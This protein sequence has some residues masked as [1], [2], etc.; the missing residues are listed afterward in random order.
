[1]RV[2]RVAALSAILALAAASVGADVLILKTGSRTDVRSITVRG[3]A[4]IVVTL[5]GKTWSLL[6]DAVDLEATRAANEPR[7][8]LVPEPAIPMPRVVIEPE[9]PVRPVSPQADPP[10][11]EERREAPA[12]ERRR[13]R[14]QTVVLVPQPARAPSPS[15]VADVPDRRYR[16]AFF[17]NGAIA[18]SPLEFSEARSFEL[19]KED[20]VFTNSYRDP[21]SQGIELGGSFRIKGPVGIGVSVELFRNDRE[22]IYSA[23]LPHPFFFEQFRE[24]SG[25]E[26]GLSHQE[27][28]LHLDAVVTAQLGPYV[29]IDVFGGPSWFRT[30]TELLV[31]VRYEELY[32]YH[33]VVPLGVESRVFEERPLGYNVGA[34]ATFRLAGPFGVDLGVRYSKARLSFSPGDGS[35]IELDAGGLRAGAGFRLQFR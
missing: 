26:A 28:A 6:D 2:A 31:D 19:F 7:Q 17:I 8:A 35:T 29:S 4:V 12:S 16:V 25:S 15:L 30:R 5:N 10:L 11:P 9:P 22:A 33:S 18:T 21:Q 23:L 13:P 3:R 34:S 27:Q 1:M 24:L 14:P 20:A 32:P